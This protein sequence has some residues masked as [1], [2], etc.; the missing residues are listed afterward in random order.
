MPILDAELARHLQK[1]KLLQDDVYA[2]QESQLRK[3]IAAD[4]QD[5]FESVDLA[6]ERLELA[7]LTA[8]NTDLLL[9]LTRTQRD[10]GTMTNQDFLTAAVNAA[11]AQTALAAARSSAQLAVLT[12]QSVMGY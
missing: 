7:R 6:R 4:I 5:A 8:E 2:A 3:S 11:N 1:E 9:E 10:F 12:L